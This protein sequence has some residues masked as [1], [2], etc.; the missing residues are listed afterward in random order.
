MM[1]QKKFLNIWN[2]TPMRCE[3]NIRIFGKEIDGD[4]FSDEDVRG[5]Q[6]KYFQENFSSD[7][8]F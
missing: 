4:Y 2:Q 3:N 6:N 5:W 8:N 1:K 7:G